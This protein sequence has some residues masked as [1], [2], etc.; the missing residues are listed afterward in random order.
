MNLGF[1]HSRQWIMGRRLALVALILI[2]AFRNYGPAVWSWLSA[3][4]PER[5]VVVV[6]SEF[7]TDLGGEKPAWVIALRNNSNS[8]TYDH[9]ELE[10]TYLDD[11]GKVLE[12]DKLAFK[13]KLT[14]GHE[15]TIAS[16]DPKPRVGATSGRLRVIGA[17]SVKP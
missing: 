13:P 15:Q 7:R 4:N 17:R 8:T 12:K 3:T 11:A 9:I 2:L 14:P 16:T 1:L 6:Q 5:D 10:A